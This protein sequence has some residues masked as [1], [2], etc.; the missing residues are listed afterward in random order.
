MIFVRT[1]PSMYSA[2]LWT[3]VSWFL[4]ANVVFFYRCSSG[5][6]VSS[7]SGNVFRETLVIIQTQDRHSGVDSKIFCL[8]FLKNFLFAFLIITV[9]FNI[10]LSS[11]SLFSSS[12]SVHSVL[13]NLS[14]FPLHADACKFPRQTFINK[15]YE[16]F[17][18]IIIRNTLILNLM[19]SCLQPWSW[20]QHVHPKQWCL[21][22]RQ[23]SV[24]AQNTNTDIFTAITQNLIDFHL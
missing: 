24:R 22:I 21:P 23:R 6:L 10:I 1:T 16:D 19:E 4:Y 7:S 17:H 15:L 14:S 5:Y 12:E 2:V 11:S 8:R 9:S 20:K 3:D 13:Q 18:R